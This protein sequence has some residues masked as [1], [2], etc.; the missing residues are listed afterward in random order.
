MRIVVDT[1]LWIRALLGGKLSLPV[2]RAFYEDRFTLLISDEVLEEL[3]E[4]TQRPRLAK[5]IDP[6]DLQELLDQIEWRAEGVII[7][8]TPPSCRDPKDQPILATAIDGF[9]DAIVT[10][11]DDLRADEALRR[12]MLD[13][14]VQLWGVESFLNS[15]STE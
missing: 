10:G 4:V 14:G 15:L 8:T 3:R 11:D 2:L 7:T 5:A 1:N 12:A 13:H 6:A 9:A